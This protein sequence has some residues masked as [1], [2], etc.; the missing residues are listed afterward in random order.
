MY[1]CLYWHH[2]LQNKLFI[3]ELWN[4]KRIFLFVNKSTFK[5]TCYII[6]DSHSLCLCFITLLCHSYQKKTFTKIKVLEKVLTAMNISPIANFFEWYSKFKWI[7]ALNYI[8][9]HFKSIFYCLYVL[10]NRRCFQYFRAFL[11]LVLILNSWL[12]LKGH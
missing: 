1:L 8:N 12:V 4:K 2:I 9:L 5:F 11:N 6:I 7:T 3:W 10:V